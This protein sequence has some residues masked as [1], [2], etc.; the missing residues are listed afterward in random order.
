M[1]AHFGG[2]VGIQARAGRRQPDEDPLG[3]AH[4]HLA[5][6]RRVRAPHIAV[7]HGPHEGG[8]RLGEVAHVRVQ[9]RAVRQ[10]PHHHREGVG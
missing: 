6:R 7:A 8:Q 5:E 3:Q 2:A 9:G 4:G 10:R 1:A